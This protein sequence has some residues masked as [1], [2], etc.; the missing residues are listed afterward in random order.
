MP[1]KLKFK[2]IID[3]R[4]MAGTVKFGVFARVRESALSA[5]TDVHTC[6][7]KIDVMELPSVQCL[8][9]MACDDINWSK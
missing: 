8:A 1:M 2:G 4:S 7:C 5:V 3:G 6:H 9:E